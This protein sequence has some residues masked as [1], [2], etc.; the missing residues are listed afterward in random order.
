MGNF[1]CSLYRALNLIDTHTRNFPLLPKE[2][3]L[4]LSQTIPTLPLRPSP[5]RSNVPKSLCPVIPFYSNY[6]G[7]LSEITFFWYEIPEFCSTKLRAE[8]SEDRPEEAFE[9]SST[10]KHEEID[11]CFINSPGLVL[12]SAIRLHRS[13]VGH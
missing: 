6:L 13:F 3:S 1:V 2:T 11:F 12:C 5:H 10:I 8:Y 4:F 7:H 9:I